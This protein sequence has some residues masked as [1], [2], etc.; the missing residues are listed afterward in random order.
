MLVNNAE[1]SSSTPLEATEEEFHRE[2]NTSVLGTILAIQEAS[3]ISR[4]IGEAL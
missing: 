1:S 2:F 4:P 3:S